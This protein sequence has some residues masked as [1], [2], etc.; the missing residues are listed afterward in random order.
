MDDSARARRSPVNRLRGRKRRSLLLGSVSPELTRQV[1]ESLAGRLALCEL[2]P[3]L[4]SE[5]PRR[6]ERELWLKGGYPDGGVLGG[7]RSNTGVVGADAGAARAFRRIVGFFDAR[8][9]DAFDTCHGTG[10]AAACV[11]SW[12]H[13]TFIQ[14]FQANHGG[15]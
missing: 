15:P 6:S 5:L 3:F 2:T 14:G 12:G 9:Q 10:L 13:A 11:L 8:M 1:S 7:T 4:V